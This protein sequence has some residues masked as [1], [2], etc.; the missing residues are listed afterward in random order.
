MTK[1][2]VITGPN[3]VRFTAT[4]RNIRNKPVSWDLWMNTRLDGKARVYVP[5]A[6]IGNIKKVSTGQG[7]GSQAIAYTR[8]EGYITFIP[9]LPGPDKKDRFTKLYLHPEAPW[10]GAF[11]KN[12]L[13]IKRF[14]AHAEELIHP[15][16]A[17][18][19][20]YNCMS[21][22]PAENVLELE[23]HGPYRELQPGEVIAE[24]E[25]WEI[26]PYTGKRETRSELQFLHG[27]ESL[28]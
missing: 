12:H 13:F 17:L 24:T 27:L 26:M 11:T 5:V 7:P 23:H 18:V 28:R 14:Q 25:E 15:E 21:Q 1:E 8:Q 10:I 22:D 6:G 19:E 20:L 2:I 16:Q 3:K 4:I 9:Q